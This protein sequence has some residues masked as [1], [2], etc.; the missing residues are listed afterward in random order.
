MEKEYI[1]ASRLLE[2]SYQ[3]GWKI[4]QS[5]FRPSLI[6]GIWRG[7][8]PVAIAVHELFAIAGVECDHLPI[9]SR[10]YKGIDSR[11]QNVEVR[12]LDLLF[13]Q[14][15]GTDTILLVD[16]VF[17]TGLSMQKVLQ[18]IH[19][20]CA[21]NLPEIRTAAPYFKPDKNRTA[22]QPDYYLHATSD[23]LVFPHELIGLTPAEIEKHKP[24]ISAIWKELKMTQ[25]K[26]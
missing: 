18:E 10:L 14:L 13:A 5:G 6:V 21:E 25:Q 20:H 23:W 22:I 15:T 3:L 26:N 11:G 2:D 12:G 24:E 9:Q 7:G 17:D 8:T 19:E 1:S 16:D 4:Y